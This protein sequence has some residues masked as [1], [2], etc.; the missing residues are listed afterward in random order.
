MDRNTLI[1]L[2]LMVLVFIGFGF[3]NSNKLKKSYESA[4]IEAD[5]LYKEG[6]YEAAK[7]KYLK[8]LE[9]KPGTPEAVNRINEI[10]RIIQPDTIVGIQ[11][12]V[13]QREQVPQQ[14]V[15][16]VGG[17]AETEQPMQPTG[18]FSETYNGK[19]EF[20]ILKNDILEVTIATKGGR[21]YSA[22]LK[23][24][25]T[26]DQRPLVLFDGDST[27]FGFKFFT[28]DNKRIETNNLYFKPVNTSQVTDATNSKA[29]AT[30]RLEVSEN[31][32][33]E[34]VYSLEPDRYMVDFDVNF[35]GLSDIMPSNMNSI[36]FD[37]KS[38]IPQQEKGR[39]NENNW[40]NI[41]YKHYQDNVDGFRDRVHKD[42]EEAD[43]TTPLRWVA[44]KDQ[45]FSSV[46]ISSG[47]F[48]NAY[49]S[50]TTMPE[51][52]KYLRYCTAELGLPFNPGDKVEYDLK[53]YLGPNHYNTLK[54]YDVGLEELVMLGK[55]VIK[56]FNKYVIVPIFNWL[57]NYIGNYGI[58]ILILTL[59]IK[60]VLFPLTFKS[61]QSQA[62]MKV[63]KPMVDEIGKKYPKKDDAMKKQQATMDLYKKAGV[64]PLG[65]CLPMALQMPILFAMFRFFPTSIE[66]RQQPF[67][68]AE[69]LSTYDSILDLPFNIPM[70][71]D[72]I[73]LFTL[74]MTASTI[75]T[76]KINSPSSTGQEQMPGM[77]MMTYI[78]PIM[79]MLIL[80]NFSAGL[81]YYYF[82]ANLITF[83]QNLISKRFIDEEAVLKRL[84]E[85]KKKPSKKSKFQQRLEA[86]AKQRG[87][88]PPKRK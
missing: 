39:Q 32:Y 55:N 62:K 19:Q 69:D 5:S 34:Y 56:F 15:K 63:L 43:I 81:T 84:N 9:F 36:S 51:D 50:Y 20:F 2:V 35:L 4:F 60:I 13:Q 80:N 1:G 24:Y 64:S 83:G 65:G 82:L 30:F 47:S 67:L 23:D 33:I 68:W 61:F 72:H 25:T 18:A 27:N 70:Y 57:D 58:I 52:S 53:L 76:M 6:E 79:F 8:A 44:F 87:Y 48:T 28:S 22:L 38:Y 71:G 21:I 74:L 42:F 66:L 77:K 54:K 3:Y 78:M 17:A 86:A 29:S 37:W 88:Q 46:L 14:E 40:A 7:L 11:D 49:V 75:I 45:F 26:Y 12:T 73:S 31:E 85:S 59:I 16:T 10:N 41:K